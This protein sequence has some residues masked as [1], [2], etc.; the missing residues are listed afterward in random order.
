MEGWK[1]GQMDEQM[2]GWNEQMNSVGKT[3]SCMNKLSFSNFQDSP[4]R[5]VC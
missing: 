3:L 4:K 5:S 1:D 2:D